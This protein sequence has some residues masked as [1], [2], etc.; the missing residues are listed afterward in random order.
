MTKRR[1]KNVVAATPSG[2]VTTEM[3]LGYIALVS[4]PNQ[5]VS[6]T[7]LRRLWLAEGLDENLVPR[8]RRPA[9]VFMAAC[10]SVESRR[11]EEDR[12]HEI[13]VDRVLESSEECVYQITQLVRDKDQRLIEHPKAMRI[14]F[15]AKDGV[16]KHEALD[17]RKL[18]KELRRLGDVIRA[19]YEANGTKVPGNK[20]R[21]AIRETLIA[22][23]STRI[24]NKG[25]FFVPKVS[26]GTLESIESV[27]RGLYKG[28]GLAELAIIPCLADAP[29][30]Q[31]IQRHYTEN[32]QGEIDSLLAECSQRL[33]AGTPVRGDRQKNLVAERLRIKEGIERYQSLLDTKLSVLNAGVTL[34]DDALEQLLMPKA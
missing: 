31:M 22:D 23:H 20:V 12:T 30:K 2:D 33:K 6:A 27:L 21:A 5:P 1:A 7:K 15:A 32:V 10:R 11:T 18:Y 4:I 3:I 17:D 14:T 8:Q 28:A 29:E 26:H 9:D 16:I 25:V 19:E 13:K 24:Q 34:L